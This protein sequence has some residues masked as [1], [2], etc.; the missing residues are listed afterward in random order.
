MIP[1]EECLSGTEDCSTDDKVERESNPLTSN[2]IYLKKCIAINVDV[3]FPL[4][5]WWR[6]EH[7]IEK[8]AETFLSSE[9]GIRKLSSPFYNLLY[10]YA[11]M[12]EVVN[13]QFNPEVSAYA[14]IRDSRLNTSYFSLGG[15]ITE[16]NEVIVESL[17]QQVTLLKIL[18]QWTEVL[19][20]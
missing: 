20:L 11:H 16:A 12:Q 19:L 5:P 15:T 1:A 2:N 3:F 14:R 6:Q 10:P 4:L 8:S 9:V 13:Y 17:L 7:S 18:W